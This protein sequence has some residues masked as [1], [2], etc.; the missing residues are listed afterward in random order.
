MPFGIKV[1]PWAEAVAKISAKTP[2][3]STLR[4]AQWDTQEL[5]IREAAFFSA[6]VES[7][8]LLSDMQGAIVDALSGNRTPGGAI[9]D[10]G[11]FISDMR[12]LAQQLGVGQLGKSEITNMQGPARL[13]LIYDMQARQAR[14]FARWKTGQDAD[15]M[16][17]FPAQRLI[18]I[19]DRKEPRDWEE[20]LNQA[21]MA[22]GFVGVARSGMIALKDSPIW[23]ELSRFGTPWPPFDYGSGMGVEDV[24][25]DEAERLGLVLPGQVIQPTGEREFADRMEASAARIEPELLEQLKEAGFQIEGKKLVFMAKLNREIEKAK[26]AFVKP[27]VVKQEPNPV[28]KTVDVQPVKD[29]PPVKKT[30]AEIAAKKAEDATTVMPV[31]KKQSKG[32]LLDDEIKKT[33]A[34]VTQIP[35]IATEIRAS[36]T[37]AYYDPTKDAIFMP[38]DKTKW[39]GEPSTFHHEFAHNIHHKTGAIPIQ[40]GKPMDSGLAKAME[41]D[42]AAWKKAAQSK[43]GNAWGSYFSRGN[44]TPAMSVHLKEL[45]LS[46]SYHGAT[47]EHRQ[48][49]LG[50]WDI[51]GGLSGGDS[52]YGHKKSYYRFDNGKYGKMEVFANLYRAIVMEWKE[53]ESAFPLTAAWIRGNL[54]L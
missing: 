50:F 51:L 28:E 14:G 27:P 45:G 33:P 42:F 34:S 47:L 1:Q 44:S 30:A 9:M 41:D 11:R 54:K 22:A 49:A 26:D 5:A 46:E 17:Q 36:K 40:Y 20:R 18:R 43:H 6:R 24:D 48:R 25:R 53:Y 35:N 12:A 16:N 21:A 2:L 10:R 29:K 4:S 13:G 39:A 52:G 15:M 31:I 23:R 7:A 32:F 8:R 38:K 3:G 19:S 37:K